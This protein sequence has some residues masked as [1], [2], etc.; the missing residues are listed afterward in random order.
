VQ[1]AVVLEDGALRV[2]IERG[3]VADA[4][5]ALVILD[6]GHVLLAVGLFVKDSGGRGLRPQGLLLRVWGRCAGA[7]A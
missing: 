6:V 5:G 7:A 3:V 1:G 4:V 2:E